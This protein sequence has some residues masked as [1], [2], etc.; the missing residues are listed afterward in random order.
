MNPSGK[1]N[2]KCLGLA[3]LCGLCFP[4][5]SF[6]QSTSFTYQ[7]KL[8]DTGWPANGSYDFQI[9]LF[10]TPTVGTGI[11][12]G[13]TVIVPAVQVTGGIF[14]ANLDFGALGFSSRLS[15]RPL[16]SNDTTP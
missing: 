4:S 16:A 9:K 13:A 5:A 15:A 2:L 8:S 12:Q 10:D 7:G 6:A 11:Q 3:I 1:R 14:T